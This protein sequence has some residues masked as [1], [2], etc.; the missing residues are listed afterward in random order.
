MH[1]KADVM[2]LMVTMMVSCLVQQESHKTQLN[3]THFNSFK[4]HHNAQTSSHAL[5]CQIPTVFISHNTRA[6]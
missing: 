3:Q 5:V 4:Q 1:N 2:K 6:M